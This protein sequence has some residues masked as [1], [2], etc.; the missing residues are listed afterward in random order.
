MRKI[1]KFQGCYH[2]WH[3]AVLR[4][5]ISAP[6]MIGKRDLLSAGMLEETADATLICTST[7]PTRWRTPIRAHE[8]EIAAII[9]EPIPHNIGCVRPLP[10]FLEAL[11]ELSNAHGIV[12]IFDEVITGFRHGLGG[13]QSFAGVTP[14]IT[15]LGKAIANGFPL[16]AVGGK[17]EIMSRFNTAPAAIRSLPVPITVTP[18]APRLLSPLSKSWRRRMCHKEVYRLGDRIRAGLTEVME[19]AGI[20]PTWRGSAPCSSPISWM[21]PRATSPTSCRTMPTSSCATARKCV[22][23][24][25]FKLPM[26]IKRNHISFAHTDADIDRTLQVGEDAIHTLL[27][28]GVRPEQAKCWSP[29]RRTCLRQ[30]SRS[31]PQELKSLGLL[32]TEHASGGNETARGSLRAAA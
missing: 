19:N 23:R 22:K 32:T 31:A 7:M 13:Y 29:R 21:A 24:G 15:T 20:P 10:G 6:D 16:A 25:V 26:N 1:I 3:D 2:G 5:V 17:R 8:G 27:R 11:R 9:V 4:N 18:S 30:R 12:L 28:Q 14:D